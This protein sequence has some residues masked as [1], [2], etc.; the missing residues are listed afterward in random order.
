MRIQISYF[1]RLRATAGV[2]SDSYD[3]EP[4]SS[5][6]S[7]LKKVD[8]ERN[9]GNRTGDATVNLLINGRNIKFL[10]GMNTILSD[11]DE[12]SIFPP[13]GGG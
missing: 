5:L 1:G 13:T 12:V 8:A 4:G 9:I 3:L 11:G 10:D 7:L 6:C 2:K